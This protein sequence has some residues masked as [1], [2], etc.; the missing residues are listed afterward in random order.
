MSRLVPQI[1]QESVSPKLSMDEMNFRNFC[2]IIKQS[3][4]DLYTELFELHRQQFSVR[5]QKIAVPKLQKIFEA[6]FRLA[7]SQ[8]FQ[9]MTLRQLATE[10]GLSMGGLYAYIHSK[11]ELAQIIHS[12]LNQYCEQRIKNLLDE[13]ASEKKQL[14]SL[15][16]IHLFLSE[17]MQPWFYF[18]YMETKNLSKQHKSTAINSE[19]WMENKLQKL[20]E[21]GIKNHNFKEN[22]SQLIASLIKALLQDWYLKRWKYKKRKISVDVYSKQVEIM[23]LRTLENS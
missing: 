18:A 14:L 6:T 11:D 20:I 19:L 23:V 13:G 10:T 2:R 16:R 12:F 21:V 5:K 8:G 15:I 7:N 22:N 4:E 9:A 17:L 1:S 3:P